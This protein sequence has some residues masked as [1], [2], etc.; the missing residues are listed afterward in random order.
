MLHPDF[1]LILQFWWP[2]NSLFSLAWTA[3]YHLALPLVER[4]K[5]SCLR[6]C[7]RQHFLSSFLHS[8]SVEEVSLIFHLDDQYCNIERYNPFPFLLQP[9]SC[10]ATWWGSQFFVTLFFIFRF[11]RILLFVNIFLCSCFLCYT[12]AV[13]IFMP[14]LSK[15]ES[16]SYVYWGGWMRVFRNDLWRGRLAVQKGVIKTVNCL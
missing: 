8:T 11:L 5:T 3:S 6:H 12:L 15:L 16:C 7:T 13:K 2:P 1:N 9:S 4:R 10:T 14:S